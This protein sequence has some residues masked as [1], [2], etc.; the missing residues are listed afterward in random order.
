MKPEKNNATNISFGWWKHHVNLDLTTTTFYGLSTHV[1]GIGRS[2]ASDWLSNISNPT[3]RTGLD[4]KS[5]QNNQV[6][7]LNQNART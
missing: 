3:M 5:A 1:V 2:K 7:G 6:R 4:F